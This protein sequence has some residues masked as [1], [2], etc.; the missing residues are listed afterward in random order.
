MF[1]LA[2]LVPRTRLLPDSCLAK[3]ATWKLPW[4]IFVQ[5]VHTVSI[6]G[7]DEGY[8]VK[9]TPSPEGV[10]KGEGL[11]LTVYPESSPIM[12]SISFKQS[13]CS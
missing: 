5:T 13:I 10:P 1:R 7:R 12:D 6:L 8:T 11:F 4:K 3:V 2:S 9:Y